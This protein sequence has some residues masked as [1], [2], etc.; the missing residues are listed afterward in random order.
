MPSMISA[1]LLSSRTSSLLCDSPL[2]IRL[3]GHRQNAFARGAA[4]ADAAVQ[5]V[6]VAFGPAGEQLL[7]GFDDFGH[8]GIGLPIEAAV[9]QLRRIEKELIHLHTEAVG[10]TAE[11]ADVRFVAA[12]ENAADGPLVEPGLF[13]QRSGPT[14]RRRPSDATGF[15]GYD[16]TWGS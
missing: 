13:R 12:V 7:V 5:L 11:S 15:R 10:E 2:A 9:E 1:W 14:S 4:L 8:D 3:P 16:P 6:E